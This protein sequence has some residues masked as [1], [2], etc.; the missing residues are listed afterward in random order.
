MFY[1]VKGGYPMKQLGEGHFYLVRED[2]L[3]ESML[4]MLEAKGFWRAE[5]NQRYKMR[6]K[7][8]AYPAVLFINIAI[9]FS[10]SNQLHANVS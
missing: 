5:K 4:K 9:L 10:L 3:T 1:V 2:V 6:Q 8:L 7:G